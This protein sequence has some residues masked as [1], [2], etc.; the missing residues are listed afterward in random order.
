MFPL[1]A[2]R[3]AEFIENLR[4]FEIINMKALFRG[5]RCRAG[6]C[7]ALEENDVLESECFREVSF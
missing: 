1:V 5:E 7:V 2:K 4:G 3:I 6:K